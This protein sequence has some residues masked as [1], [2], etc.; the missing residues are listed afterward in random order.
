LS[1]VTSW[2]VGFVIGA[3]FAVLSYLFYVV[4][5]AILSFSFGYGLTEGILT[6]I[7][8]S[9][10]LIIFIIALIVGAV[11]TYAVLKYNIQKY[12]IIVIT[13]MGGTAAVIYT[14]LAGFGGLSPI[15]LL[16]NPVLVAIGSSFW[17]AL[18]FVVVAAAG[19]YVQLKAN[20]EY[21]IEEY[22]RWEG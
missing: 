17:W 2:V 16:M 20:P 19:V 18:F 8:L 1:T 9:T 21:E 4:A 10:E 12:A 6:W 13:A 3:I 15:E 11:V 14:L 7:G 5:V 22:S